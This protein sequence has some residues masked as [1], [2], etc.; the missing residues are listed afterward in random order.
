MGFLLLFFMFVFV[1]LGLSGCFV[2]L[3][4]WFLLFFGVFLVL[5]FF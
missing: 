1:A 4:G 3:G 2:F 5:L